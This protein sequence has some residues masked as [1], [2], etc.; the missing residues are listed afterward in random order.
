[1]Y[2]EIKFRKENLISLVVAM[3]LIC[4]LFSLQAFAVETDDVTVPTITVAF[5]PDDNATQ[6]QDFHKVMVHVGDLVAKPAD[7]VRDGYFF[8]G[9]YSHFDENDEPVFWDFENNTVTEN[10]T[11]WAAWEE[12]CIVAFDPDDGT[13]TYKDFYK[14]PVHIGDLITEKPAN[15]VREGYLFKGWYSHFDE[16]DAPVFWDFENGTVEHN[17]TLWAAWEKQS[18]GG[19]NHG[20]GNPGT[21]DPGPTNPGTTDPDE[22]QSGEDNGNG[23]EE[24]ITIED[25]DIPTDSGSSDGDISTGSGSSDGEILDETPKT[26]DTSL[27]AIVYGALALMSLSFLGLCLLKRKKTV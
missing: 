1:M 3:V 8:Q 7:P 22:G 17:T 12:G 15:P 23:G 27:S 21:T 18:K 20:G 14:V 5:D 13:T 16:N 9:W 4:G 2:Q 19:G 6:Y 11:L 24:E 25:G 26:G 10:T